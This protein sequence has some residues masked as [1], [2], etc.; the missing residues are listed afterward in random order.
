MSLKVISTPIKDELEEFDKFFKSLMKTDVPLLDIVL[1]YLTKKKGKRIR[2]ILVFLTA[3]ILGEINERTYNGAAMVELLHT[4]TLV[5]DDVVDRAETRRGLLSIN[6]KWNNKIAVLVGD[7]LLS[8]GLLIATENKEYGFLD[9]TSDAVRRMS[10]GELQAIEVIKTRVIT[11]EIYYRIISDKTAA[12]ISS[13]TRIGAA[14]VTDDK[15]I[16]EKMRVFGENIGMAFQLKDDL[17]DYVAESKLIGKP[18]GNDIKEKK[19][20]LPLIH[21]FDN[22][23]K[24]ESKKIKKMIKKGDLSNSDVKYIIDFAKQNKGIDYTIEKSNQYKEKAL[25][26]LDGIPMTADKQMLID[27]AEFVINREN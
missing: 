5:H 13:C 4:A 7:F 3:H 18:V 14:S 27:L 10:E 9:I 26:A 17:F 24:S 8:K 11:E 19:I 1:R 16:I 22:A 12:L 6:A 21:A 2:P 20:T 23:D 25:R 15:E